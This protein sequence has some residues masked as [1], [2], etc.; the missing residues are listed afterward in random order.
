MA[1]VQQVVEAIV[2][3]ITTAV[4]TEARRRCPVDTG[5]LRASIRSQVTAHGSEVRGEVY[6]DLDHAAYV[7][8][9][10]GIYG[11]RNRP[12]QPRRAKVLAWPRPGGGTVFARQSRGQRPQPWLLE[13]LEA[14]ATGRVD[15]RVVY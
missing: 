7:H 5:A 3:D 14:V 4:A 15:R 9:G 10:T 6:S 13:A 8:Q 11:P 12:I 2:G 1:A